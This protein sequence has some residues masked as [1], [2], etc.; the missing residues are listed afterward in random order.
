MRFLG[1]LVDCVSVG[2][3]RRKRQYEWYVGEGTI[4]RAQEELSTVRGMPTKL[5]SYGTF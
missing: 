5:V 4:C 3:R 1:W 2:L